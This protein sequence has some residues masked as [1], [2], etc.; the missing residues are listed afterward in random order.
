MITIITPTIL[1]TLG[2]SYSDERA[3]SLIKLANNSLDF[4]EP[5]SLLISPKGGIYIGG[6]GRFNEPLLE[7]Y[8]GKKI[9][10]VVIVGTDEMDG[11]EG[12]VGESVII[13]IGVDVVRRQPICCQ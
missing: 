6:V 10:F 3:K 1:D 5:T 2:L 9:P 7:K 8:F 13:R 12:V 4:N 11:A